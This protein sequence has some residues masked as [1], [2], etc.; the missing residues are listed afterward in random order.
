MKR[1]QSVLALAGL[2][3]MLTAQ[4]SFA[5]GVINPGLYQ[6]LDHGFG[7]LGPDYGLR[8]DSINAVFST[9]L[10][11]ASVTLDWDGGTTALISGMLNNNTTNELWDV[12]YT[13][14]GLVAVGTQG[15]TATMGSGT[16]TDPLNN[17]TV[18]TGEQDG[19]GIA[20]RFLADGHRLPGDN[21]TAVGRGWLLPPNSTDDWLVRAVLI[22]EPASLALF[23][24]G[25][26]L[27][28]RRKN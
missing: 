18:M 3:L 7:N 27:L 19:S 2:I 16:L 28:L 25:G 8:V 23:A 21:D 13:L 5:V 15:F 1:Y 26:L 9:E 4:S 20:F 12:E 17:A 11:G 10:G 24:S 6:L 22:P 14:T